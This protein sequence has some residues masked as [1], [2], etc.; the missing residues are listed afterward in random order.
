VYKAFVINNV[1]EVGEKESI[2]ILPI[3]SQAVDY[4]DEP[5]EYV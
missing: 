1:L 4:R 5:V 3:T 2:L